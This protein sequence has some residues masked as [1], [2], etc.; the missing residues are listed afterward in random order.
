MRKHLLILPLALVLCSCETVKERVV[1]NEAQ[2][3]YNSFWE[4]LY[5]NYVNFGD[6]DYEAIYE[7]GFNMLSEIPADS[8]N[9]FIQNSYA[10]K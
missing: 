4:L 7:K 6:A 9:K 1:K 2:K 10:G 5:E 3:L 8:I